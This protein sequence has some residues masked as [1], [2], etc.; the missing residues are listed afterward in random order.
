MAT[1]EESLGKDLAFK[2]DL[3]RGPTGDLDTL[4]GVENVR[5]ALL[6][7]L[8]TVPGSLIH[9]P[10]YGVGLK[11]FQNA[12]NTLA[13][14]RALAIRIQEQFTQ[15]PR[16]EK[17]EGVRIEK[18]DYQPELVYVIIRVKIVGYGETEVKSTPFGEVT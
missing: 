11:E 4:S 16:V 9:R 13:V 5:Q 10:T 18:D 7:R 2:T 8:I 1:I 12:P 17:V 15:D 14:L 6:H 3:V